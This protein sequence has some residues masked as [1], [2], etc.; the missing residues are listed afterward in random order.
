[1]AVRRS[2]KNYTHTGDIPLSINPAPFFISEQFL[3]LLGTTE[4]YNSLL[5]QGYTYNPT[6]EPL[7]YLQDSSRLISG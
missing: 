4:R 3:E 7:L 6:S 5:S 2:N 1:M